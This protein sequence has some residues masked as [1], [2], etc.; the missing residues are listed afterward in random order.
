MV[1]CWQLFILCFLS[2][3]VLLYRGSLE[4]YVLGST[5]VVDDWTGSLTF[6][7]FWLGALMMLSTYPRKSL[8]VWGI[9]LCC[10]LA[11][12]S[13]SFFWFYIF[14]ELSLVP[15]FVLILRWG[16]QPERIS[17]A[18]YL[19]LYTLTGSLPFLLFILSCF[20]VYGS[21]FMG[22]SWDLLSS[23][24]YWGCAGVMV[25]FIK[26]PCY[27]FHLWLTKAH[28]E[29][30]TAGSMALA[31]LLLKLGGVGLMR[32]L[33]SYGQLCYSMEVFW[34]AVGI[35]GGVLSSI[36]CLRQMDSKSLVAYS[37]VGHMSLVQ[38]SILSGSGLGWSGALYMMVAH[39]LCSSG[40]FSILGEYYG[41]VKSRSMSICMGLN[42]LFPS[43]TIWWCILIVCSMSC[44]PGLA[45][46]GEIFMGMSL[47]GTFPGFCLWFSVVGFLGGA[48]SLILYGG[49]SHGP[50][51]S[52]L[53][54]RFSGI[55]KCSYL[56][57]LHSAPLFLL[58]FFPMFL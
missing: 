33:K 18:F 32:V 39:G 17:A 27:P 55:S 3:P 43:T 23:M 28:V 48:Y 13:Y 49:M 46:L 2:A 20:S 36:V 45:F 10:F 16:V 41:K 11:F 42:M 12:C 21:F 40:L 25:F 34:S 30:P 47:A 6:L 8:C 14:F 57:L 54:P 53:R 1:G 26:M 37:S 38:L 35:W 58:F 19:M 24:G 5:W 56:G 44:P 52:S 51:G 15:V 22:F 29:A 4:G 7:S 50:C 9:V 31:G